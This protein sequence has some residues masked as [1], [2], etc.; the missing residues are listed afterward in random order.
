MRVPPA[1]ILLLHVAVTLAMAGLC[2]FVQVV[3]YPL[4][5]A[6]GEGAFIEYSHLHSRRTTWVVAP[7]MLLELGS[8]AVLMAL[9]S[10][11]GREPA[12]L[13]VSGSLRW[14]WVA[15]GLLILIWLSTFFVQVPLHS[16]L[17]QGFDA[18]IASRLVLTN[19]VRTLLWTA[20][21]AILLALL[22]PLLTQFTKEG[23]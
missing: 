15:M 21:G 20:R 19:W 9:A 16:K 11:A 6:V 3:H 1:W 7:L 17:A 10:V 14:F 18:G 5:A 13:P 8:G 22:S 4:F 23:I 12:A 2:W